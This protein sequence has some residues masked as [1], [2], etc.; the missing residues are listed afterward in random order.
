[1]LEL[2]IETARARGLKTMVGHVLAGN[3]AMLVLCGKLGFRISDHPEDAGVKR[4]TLVLDGTG[5]ESR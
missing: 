4:A 5:P 3:Q 1:M 2:L